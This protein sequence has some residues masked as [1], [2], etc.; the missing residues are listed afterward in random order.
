MPTTIT[1]SKPIIAIDQTFASLTLRD[2]VGEDLAGGYP[3]RFSGDGKTEIDATAM[4]ILIGRL[5]GVPRSSVAKL[6]LGDWNECMKAVMDF[7]APTA[8]TSSTDI[9]NAPA[10][11]A[12]STTS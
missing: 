9:S 5:A 11:G 10:S 12:T 3:V 2:P 4:T 7:L 8:P 6:P 1:L